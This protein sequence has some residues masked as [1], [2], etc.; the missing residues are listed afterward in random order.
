[1]WGEYSA[2]IVYSHGLNFVHT[3]VIFMWVL[4]GYLCHYKYKVGTNIHNTL[5]NHCDF[6]YLSACAYVANN[7][8][9]S[10]FANNNCCNLWNYYWYKRYMPCH[11]GYD[12]LIIPASSSIL[13]SIEHFYFPWMIRLL[14]FPLYF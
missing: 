6:L 9:S 14:V 12:E 13:A 8:L 5:I 2:F 7:S 11:E 3:Q 1:M 4:C 10:V